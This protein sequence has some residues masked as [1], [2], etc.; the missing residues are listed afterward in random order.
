MSDPVT[1]RNEAKVLAAGYE[2][3]VDGRLIFVPA[4][5]DK[6]E[7]KPEFPLLATNTHGSSTW[8]W[9][10]FPIDMALHLAIGAAVWFVFPTPVAFA[11]GALA[12]LAASF[13]HRTFV[14]RL[15]RTTLGK[16][17]FGLRIRYA[18]GTYPTLGRLVAEWFRGAG[19]T[20]E[21]CCSFG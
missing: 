21:L 7:S 12:W 13:T 15:T 2:R 19:C 17:L 16:S 18:D 10:A 4:V 5:P 3:D 1:V 6:P 11:Y 20:I 8:M 14:Q 9:L